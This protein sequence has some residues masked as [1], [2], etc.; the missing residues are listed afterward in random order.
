MKIT[1]DQQKIA[2]I[3]KFINDNDKEA[4]IIDLIKAIN[5]ATEENNTTP[6]NICLDGWEATAELNS[7]PGLSEKVWKRYNMLVKAGLINE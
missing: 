2:E 5:K 1:I 6:I 4:F 3:L 7:I